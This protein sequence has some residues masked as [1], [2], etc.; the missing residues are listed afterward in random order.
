[1]VLCIQVVYRVTVFNEGYSQHSV[2]EDNLVKVENFFKT[3]EVLKIMWT[4]KICKF[5]VSIKLIN[6]I[7]ELFPQSEFQDQMASLVNFAKYL[8]KR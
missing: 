7:I 6:L 1:M 4:K 8:W 3:E 5:S 2:K